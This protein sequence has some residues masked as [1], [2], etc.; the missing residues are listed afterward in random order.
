MFKN[1]MNGIS[2]SALMLR[3]KENDDGGDAKAKL[4]TE[5][6]KGNITKEADASDDKEDDAEGG[7]KEGDDEDNDEK[8]EGDDKEEEDENL[9]DE[10]K[11]AKVEAE[12]QAEK[13][14]AKAKRKEDRTQRRIDELTAQAKTARE[15]LEAFKK[16]NP[17]SKLSEEEVESRATAKAAEK[18]AAKNLEDIQK[19]F[20]ATCDKLQKDARKID[21]NFD[22][23]IADIADQFGRI[24]SFMI[25]VLDDFDNG[26]EVLTLI[27]NDDDLAEK[28]W[29]LKAKP[30][31]MT[32]ELVLISNQL[33]EA[34][35][36]PRKEISKVPDPITKVT[37]S[38]VIN[39]AV[40]EADTKDMDRYVAKRQAQI[41]E[42][43][44]MGR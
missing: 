43:R 36:K 23:K 8:E 29:D 2:L 5:L 35:K 40:T 10:E 26:A 30:A 27:A 6:A 9:T 18:L 7:D 11:A 3:D 22:D 44:K 21:K 12:K 32:K 33:L 14:A 19:A 16:A 15:E 41:A 38:R 4:R 25:G 13:I 17:D 24:P 20:E 42:R 28:I 39:G 31:K 37:G 34:K 1:L